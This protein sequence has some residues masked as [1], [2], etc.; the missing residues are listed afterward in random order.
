V[1]VAS[2]SPRLQAVSGPAR[3]D[4]FLGSSSRLAISRRWVVHHS[5]STIPGDL[6]YFRR[7]VRGYRY[8]GG[9]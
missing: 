9:T 4:A 2:K 8:L 7:P 3:P 1:V 5:T 6:D